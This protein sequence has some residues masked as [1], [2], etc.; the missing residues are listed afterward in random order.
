MDPELLLFFPAAAVLALLGTRRR[1]AQRGSPTTGQRVET[2]GRD[3][4]R[5]VGAALA[6][7]A[8][9]PADVSAGA[10]QSVVAGAGQLV[11]SGTGLVVDGGASVLGAAASAV[12]SRVRGR[13]APAPGKKSTAARSRARKRSA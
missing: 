13:P 2:S 7:A 8:R 6:F 11:A 12:P 1:A 3:L 9:K 4:A 5:Q 10:V